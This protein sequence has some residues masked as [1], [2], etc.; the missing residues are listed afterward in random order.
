M[1]TQEAIYGRERAVNLGIV[2]YLGSKFLLL[3]VVSALQTLLLL[4]VV[5]GG[6]YLLHLA[7]GH[8]LPW[9]GYRLGFAGEF[10][11]MTLLA[12][13]G[14]AAGLLLSACVTSPDRATALLPYV[15]IP[16]IILGGGILPIHSGP[17]HAAAV[18]LSPA[19]WGFRAV[20]RGATTLP[21]DLPFTMSYNDSVGLA[22]LALALQAVA[23]LVLSAWAL[24]QKDV[25]RA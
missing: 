4:G 19:Y 15:L 10:G 7:F 8:A 11:V 5:F 2:P 13:V 24:R 25:H 16:Q 3:S 14:V 22:C 17:L 1:A 6:L 18:L 9:P 21:A 23:L 12:M 20:R